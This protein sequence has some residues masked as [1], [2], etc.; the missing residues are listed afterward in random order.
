[1]DSKLALVLGATGGVGGEMA[2]ALV[3][4]GWR[5]QAMHRDPDRAK[6][7]PAFEWVRGDA[8]N[9]GAVR[10]AAAGAAL[11]VHAVNPPG[12]RNWAGLALPM[13]DATIAAAAAEGARVFFP[14]TVYN[15]GPETFPLVAEDA[16]QRPRTRKGAIRVEM[17]RRLRESGVRTLI[18]RGGDF[19]GPNVTAA[20]SWFAGGMVRPGQPVRF[21]LDPARRGA[22][23]N[24]AY[25]PDFVETAMRLLE[26]ADEL[27]DA[28]TF[29]FGGHWFEPGREMAL[30]I[31][32]AA[33]RR[34]PIWPFPH[35]LLGMMAPFVETLKEMREMRYLWRESLRLDNRQLVA[36]LGAEPHTP[37]VDA[38]RATL[39][40]LGCLPGSFHIP[41]G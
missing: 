14:G 10:A 27:P 8:M 9:A 29:H 6:G 19:F 21:V 35:A 41:P 23:H 7:S 18:L 22:G 17:E 33:G 2:R 5:V 24:W 37:A 11:I 25:L 34:L 30:A 31:A 13:L 32:Q 40:G 20:N 39:S 12:Y 16:P 36:F 1:M 3:A 38:V 28:A 4:R 26:R 15:F